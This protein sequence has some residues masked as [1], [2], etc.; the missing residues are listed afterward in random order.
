MNSSKSSSSSS[1]NSNNNSNEW[2]SPQSIVIDDGNGGTTV[3]KATANKYSPRPRVPNLPLS[4][5]N[6]NLKG[7]A[8]RPIGQLDLESATVS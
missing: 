7:G 1:S 2:S 6:S 5:T 8:Q 3:I 4:P